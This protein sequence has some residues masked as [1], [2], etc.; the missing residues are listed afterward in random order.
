M[1]RRKVSSEEITGF[2]D[3]G[4]AATGE[5]HFSGTLRIDG[6]FYGSIETS[7]VLIIGLKAV[8]QADIKAGEV[9]VHGHISGSIDAKRRVE[10]HSTGRLNADVRTPIIVIEAGGTFDGRCRM[11]VAEK[12]DNANAGKTELEGVDEAYGSS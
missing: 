2:L 5:L 9:E 4:T 7:D 12:G 1:R 3:H 6:H 8:V 10:I 11:A